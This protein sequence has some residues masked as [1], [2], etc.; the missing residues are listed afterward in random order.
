MAKV[1]PLTKQKRQTISK[2][3]SSTNPATDRVKDGGKG[4]HN[5]RSQATIKRLNMYKGGK[6]IRN[7]K[8]QVVKAAAFQAELASG[9]RARV[10][11]NRRWFGNTRVISQNSL[12]KFQSEIGKVMKDPYQIIL[13]PS[14]LPMSLLHD[15]AKPITQNAR[16]HILDTQSFETTFGKKSTRKRPNITV[17]DVTEMSKQI[18]ETTESYDP[19]KDNDLVREWD[20]THDIALAH[21]FNAGQSRRIWNELYKVLD[22]SDVVIQVLD[23]RDPMG[24]RCPRV[25]KYL[26]KEKPHKH[27]IFALN[28]VD[29]V[30]TWITKAWV[31]H[32]SK[33]RPTLAFHASITNP[34]GKGALINLLRQFGKLHSDKKTISCGFIGYPNVGKSSIINTLRK[35]KVCKVAPLAGET[36]VW[37]YI[38]LMKRIFLVDCPGIVHPTGD[39]ETEIILKGVVRV[40]YVSDADQHIGEILRRVKREY[41]SKQYL[42]TEWEDSEDFLEQVAK[43][44]GKLLKGGVPDLKTVAKMILNDW[45][46]GKIPYF[47]RPP[48]FNEDSEQ[49]TLVTTQG[50]PPV[51]TTQDEG[52]PPTDPSKPP[53]AI[54]IEKQLEPIEQNLAEV[55]MG[56]E[57]VEDD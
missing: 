55:K 5:M 53:N 22:C 45:Q 35:K 30:P 21:F 42:I 41:L 9:T 33:E 36:K 29:L 24:T 54:E 20:G 23:A 19:V 3:A 57:F 28:K 49:K 10:E 52:N 31:A 46:R 27:L 43:R 2:S 34:F 26:A 4:G 50:I 38:T 13:K 11:P 48:G 32:L 1:K 40:E 18:C 39:T 14:K 17:S 15:R 6:P 7:R 8:G 16:V 56:L 47:V 44:T 25:E 51:E 12:Q 37:Q